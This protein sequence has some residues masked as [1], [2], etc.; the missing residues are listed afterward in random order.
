MEIRMRDLTIT[1][2]VFAKAFKE[3]MQEKDF[4]KI[5]ISDICERS[6]MV[7]K[8]FYHHFKDKYDITNWIFDT[9]FFIIIEE[10]DEKDIWKRYTKICNYFYENKAYYKNAMR[11][12]GQNSFSDYFRD[13]MFSLISKRLENYDLN[14]FQMNFL[15]DMVVMAFYKWMMEDE[16]MT[17]DEFMNNIR[18]SLYC[19]VI[20]YEVEDKS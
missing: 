6:R 17:T 1:K 16:D 14:E 5:R 2:N 10:K 20:Q 3:L 7:R 19:M 8:S 18:G 4:K 12:Q 13:V 15:T 9:E 11:I